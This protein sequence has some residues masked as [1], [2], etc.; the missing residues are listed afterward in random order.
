MADL[1]NINTLNTLIQLRR[2][3]QAQWEAVK[4]AFIPAAGEPCITLDG[5]M[6][7][8]LKLGDGVSSWGDLKYAGVTDTT[9][10]TADGKALIIGADGVLTLNGLDSATPG[11]SFKINEDG[12]GL[13]WF[14]PVSSEELA[15][16][17][18][19]KL[20]KEFTSEDGET[21]NIIVNNADGVQIISIN[22]TDGNKGG[23]LII[24]KDGVYYSNGMT[25]DVMTADNELATK[26][27]IQGAMHFRGTVDTETNLPTNPEEG[28]IYQ[29][30]DTEKM[31]IWNGTAWDEFHVMD[32][33][34]YVTED[35]L[36][37]TLKDYAT[38]EALEKGDIKVKIPDATKTEAGLMTPED[39]KA[40]ADLNDRANM[41]GIKLVQPVVPGV[42]VNYFD[43]EMR[44]MFPADTNWVV[45]REGKYFVPIRVYAPSKAKYFKEEIALEITD[46]TFYEFTNNEFA[47]TDE[48]GVNYSLI[49]VPVA[50]EESDGT[51]TYYG[52]K[53]TT[54]HFVG[55]FYHVEW[56]DENKLLIGSNIYRINLSN[57]A[58]LNVS[59][60]YYIAEGVTMEKVNQAIQDAL[61]DY[62]VS[63]DRLY[64]GT[65]IFIIDGGTPVVP[66]VVPPVEGGDTTTPTVPEGE[67]AGA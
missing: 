56:Y 26:A 13:E 31:V 57:E 21:Q 32:M 12:T 55:W 7:G 16:E 17:L 65:K 10:I 39:K 58:L 64:N 38:I 6:K 11:Q 3:T 23:R 34:G 28:D 37:V 50:Q 19:K 61:D 45:N 33:S 67:S 62:M 54:S 47:G 66:P 9:S 14:H 52:A 53:S 4:D 35:E 46:P 15:N 30:T 44:M 20:D 8:Q 49:W 42:V 51:W 25:N 63:T 48:N 36:G 40:L 59:T 24:R 1:T 60:P 43:N 22:P 27:D 2:G 29:I 5:K 41:L 18:K